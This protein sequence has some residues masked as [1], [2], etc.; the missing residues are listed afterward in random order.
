M[1]HIKRQDLDNLRRIGRGGFGIVYQK[2]EDTAYKIYTPT[3][4]NFNDMEVSNPALLRSKRKYN[5]IISIGKKLNYTD[6]VQDCIYIDGKFGGISIPYYDG[7]TL[8]HLKNANF[9][10]KRNIA[11]Q[12]IRNAK[13]L[14]NHHIYP[15]DYKL[16]NMIYV[17]D[18]VKFIDLDDTRTLYQ[19]RTNKPHKINCV[20]KIDQ[21]LDDFFHETGYRPYSLTVASKLDKNQPVVTIKSYEDI[22]TKFKEKERPHKILLIN[23]DSDL[24]V[25]SSFLRDNLYDVFFVYD[26]KVLDDDYFMNVINRLHSYNI[27]IHKLICRT[28]TN[29]IFS[30]YNTEECTMSYEKNLI[31]K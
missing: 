8:R 4:L 24:D 14:E 7:P 25:I 23:A 6:L 12:I 5:Y 28:D 13:E 29:Q 31:K 17:G 30:D 16:A 3:V 19:R 1:I 22:L 18:E 2:D 15:T 9:S 27:P 10:I 20:R 26:K 11:H 21:T